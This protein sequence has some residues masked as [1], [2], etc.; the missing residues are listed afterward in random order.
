MPLADFVTYHD[1][2]AKMR[3]AKQ[4]LERHG[5]PFFLVAGIKRPH[6]NWRSP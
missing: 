4:N 5:Q 3:F 1:A 2:I 6:L